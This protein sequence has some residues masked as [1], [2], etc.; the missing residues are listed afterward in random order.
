MSLGKSLASPRVR[1]AVLAFASLLAAVV[2]GAGWG[3]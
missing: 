1:L 2:V 3:P